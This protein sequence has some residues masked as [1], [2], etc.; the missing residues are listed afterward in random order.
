MTLILSLN[1]AQ[2]DLYVVFP[3]LSENRENSYFLNVAKKL[4]VMRNE[5]PRIRIREKN[6][7][8]NHI[9]LKETT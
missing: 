7:L 2:R 6:V 1:N 5:K 9:E 4:F 8:I 3:F